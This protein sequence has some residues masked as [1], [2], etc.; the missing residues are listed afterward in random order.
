[1]NIDYKGNGVIQISKPV[2]IGTGYIYVKQEYK[3]IPPIKAKHQ[4][5]TYV[6]NLMAESKNLVG[7]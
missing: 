4:F 5:R 7:N 6:H 3:G 2:L 1:M